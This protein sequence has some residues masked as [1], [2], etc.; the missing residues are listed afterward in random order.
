MSKFSDI[1]KELGYELD[2]YWNSSWSKYWNQALAQMTGLSN[3]YVLGE[4]KAGILNNDLEY[5]KNSNNIVKG[6]DKT[7]T[8]KVSF[9]Y[10]TN[11]GPVTSLASNPLL[12]DPSN[13]KRS[14]VATGNSVKIEQ[15]TE[16]N[17]SVRTNY[18]YAESENGNDVIPSNSS[19]GVN[20]ESID[21]ANDKDSILQ[22]TDRWFR[23]YREDYI[24]D[25]FQTII[26]R[27]HTNKT[28]DLEN[29]I[30]NSS[31]SNTYGMSHG[32]NLLK[33]KKSNEN[34]YENPYCRVWTWHHQ[35][36]KL[37]DLIRPFIGSDND[38]IT[39]SE[40]E[41]E[42][43]NWGN[44][45][46]KASGE[47]F[48][49]GGERLAEYGVMYDNGGKTNGFVNITPSWVEGNYDDSKNVSLKHCMFS[50][51]NLAWQG[52]FKDYNDNLE[53]FGLSRE[54]KG[55]LGGRI[56]WFPPYDLQFNEGTSAN[57][58]ENVFIGR[59]E[60]IYTY[61]NSK[62][63]GHLSFKLLIDHPAILDYWE[64]RHVIGNDAESGVDNID[65][66]EQEMLRFF[67]G[68]SIL[69]AGDI[70][71][72]IHVPTNDSNDSEDSDE[73]DTKVDDGSKSFT[74]YV[75][76]PNNYSGVDDRDG[77][78]N[79]IDYLINGVG[80]QISN[81]YG[82]IEDFATNNKDTYVTLS[83][84]KYVGGYEMRDVGIS[85]IDKENNKDVITTVKSLPKY[86]LDGGI[87]STYEI[88]LIK[89]EDTK[90]GKRKWAYRVDAN[91]VTQVLESTDGLSYVDSCSFKLNS[92]GYNK[93]VTILNDKEG[94]VYSLADVYAAINYDSSVAETIDD[95]Y[96]VDN[97]NIIK[98][99]L[100]GDFGDIVSITCSGMASI[101]GKN[102]SQEVNEKRNKELADNRAKTI[103][104]WLK[105]KLK[106]K[107]Q[108]SVFSI[109]ENT[110]DKGIVSDNRDNVNYLNTKV[111]RNAKVVIK[112]GGSSTAKMQ[113]QVIINSDGELYGNSSII[114]QDINNIV[115]SE[116]NG[117][118]LKTKSIKYNYDDDKSYADYMESLPK[119]VRYDNEAIFF[120]RLTKEDPFMTKLLSER[121]KYF[122]PVFHSMSPEG[123]NARLTFLNQCMHQGP[124]YSGSD[125][126]NANANNLAFGKAPVCV[127]RIGDFYNTKIIINNLQISYDPLTWDMNQEGIG[128]MPMIATVS[129][130][131]NFIGGSDLG[132]PI[133][134]LQ[135]AISFNYYANTSVYDN[136][137]EEIEYD[138]L[139][140]TKAFKANTATGNIIY[141]NNGQ[142]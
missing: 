52:I 38:F 142:E 62:R 65:S 28:N 131:F 30:S 80:A 71:D 94:D 22:K 89:Q 47:N 58:E 15:T 90:L 136:R 9:T 138:Y 42:K 75:F 116:V 111:S 123:F 18:V 106:N 56:M 26:S 49:S 59:G 134:R 34:G 53:E 99:I 129:L 85:I 124:T 91:T 63:N 96:N 76:Y 110:V 8:D 114:S 12:A 132:G 43:Y 79:A 10:Y 55:P 48:R 60:P 86:S 44:F 33:T 72:N 46:T 100:N 3:Y 115:R 13:D 78:V 14:D 25:R 103:Q 82:D 24:N 128:V 17:G 125:T 29:S 112:Y 93:A 108:D 23:K 35:Y 88:E 140:K 64:R 126:N 70:V 4:K 118:L 87:K 16:K 77:K 101:Q 113:T 83:G 51:E 97:V 20:Y 21:Y 120:N 69:K 61:S 45:R 81:L 41:G 40:L 107:V 11:E 121:I 39:Q 98:K 117:D 19:F 36:N 133:Q 104:Y 68:C 66:K 31:F 37:N 139:G 95:L 5:I 135:N 73:N 27:F 130:D 32:R 127:L 92:T 141:N 2:E 119:S 105:S 6:T 137:A 1:A 84:D 7:I 67:A 74:F 54:Q 109:G 50:I 122:N 102:S 57:W